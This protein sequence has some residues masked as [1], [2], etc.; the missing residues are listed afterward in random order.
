MAERKLRIVKGTDI[1]DSKTCLVQ[2]F[3]KLYIGVPQYDNIKTDDGALIT[4]VESLADVYEVTR[5]SQGVPAQKPGEEFPTVLISLS[6]F[7]LTKI[8]V[9]VMVPDDAM[10][11]ELANDS[12]Y[13]TE[14]VRVKSGINLVSAD[15][16]PRGGH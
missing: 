11:G 6:S 9:I 5:I 7:V 10:V 15:K 16:L 14:Y 1:G 12:P 3:D 8:G 4:Y 2:I 13:Y